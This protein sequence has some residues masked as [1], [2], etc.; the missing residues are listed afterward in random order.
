V[1]QQTIADESSEILNMRK[2]MWEKVAKRSHFPK[3]IYIFG[4][5]DVMLFGSVD[6]TLKDG[7]STS[8]EWAARSHF[9]EED[10]ELK[11]NFYQ[12]YLVGDC[13]ALP[14]YRR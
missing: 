12:V 4:P 11:M 2:G 6:Y 14:M 1:C 7:K 9:T 13:A 10:G 3:K 5:D 8:V